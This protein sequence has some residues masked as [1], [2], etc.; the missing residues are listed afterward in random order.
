[1]RTVR[2]APLAVR[3]GFHPLTCRAAGRDVTENSG[4]LRW[5]V[6]WRV[7]DHWIGVATGWFVEVGTKVGTARL[8][9]LGA[10]PHSKNWKEAS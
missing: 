1:M 9:V 8:D 7:G 5:R 4:G 6:R 2:V 10:L 3:A